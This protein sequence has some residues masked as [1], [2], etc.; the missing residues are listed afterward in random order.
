MMPNLMEDPDIVGSAGYVLY[1]RLWLAQ[2]GM[3]ASGQVQAGYLAEIAAA[4]KA[5]RRALENAR[6]RDG[7]FC[8]WTM[9]DADAFI[10]KITEYVQVDVAAGAKRKKFDYPEDQAVSAFATGTPQVFSPAELDDAGIR[11]L[12]Q[13]TLHGFWGVWV[14]DRDFRRIIDNND[15]VFKGLID[16]MGAHTALAGNDHGHFYPTDDVDTALHA[17]LAVAVALDRVPG[18]QPFTKI[19]NDGWMTGLVGC[20]ANWHI[21]IAVDQRGETVIRGNFCPLS[22]QQMHDIPIAKRALAA[23]GAGMELKARNIMAPRAQAQYE[24]DM[25]AIRGFQAAQAVMSAP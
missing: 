10:R 6:T 17:A 19:T 1:H 9:R 3:A 5:C 21:V 20:D 15:G 7:A 13:M 23:W 14:S 2:A 16:A 22:S 18:F 24:R 4:T 25:A 11:I 12:P 8:Y